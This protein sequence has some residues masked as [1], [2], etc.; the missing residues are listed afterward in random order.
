MRGARTRNRDRADDLVQDALS[1]PGKGTILA[2]RTNLGAWL[3]TIMHNQKW[4]NVR[5]DVRVS[6]AVDIELISTTLLPRRS[7]G[8]AQDG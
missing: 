2:A 4:N 5:R 3:F 8:V 1:R 6:A 7:L